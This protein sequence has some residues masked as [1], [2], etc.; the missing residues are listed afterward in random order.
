MKNSRFSVAL[1]R[2][3]VGAVTFA[4][5][6]AGSWVGSS[7]L[8]G[9]TIGEASESADPFGWNAG[10]LGAVLSDQSRPIVDSDLPDPF[11][12]NDGSNAYIYGT[13]I[14]SDSGWLNVPVTYRT[15]DGG[16]VVVDAMPDVPSWSLEGFVWAPSVLSVADGYVMYVT[17][18][19]PT[20]GR[21]CI[22]M[23]TSTSPIGP[24]VDRSDTPF[25]CQSDL[26]GTIDASPLIDDDGDNWLLYKNDGNCCAI[27]TTIWSQRLS[28]DGTRLVGESNALLSATGGWEGWLIEG[29]S[30]VANGDAFTLFY[31]ANRWDTEEYAIGYATCAGPAGPCER[32]I[33]GPWV[34][35]G[36]GVAGPGGQEFIELPRVD[37][38]LMVMH[39]WDDDAVGY[40]VGGQR[41]TYLRL[42]RMTDEGPVLVQ[43]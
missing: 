25:V 4:M 27:D 18:H 14:A 1:F 34:E 38:Y 11:L 17:T 26:G 37:V 23:S 13:N 8:A 3:G 32:Q 41:S 12:L 10:S 36:S 29:P 16:S 19:D 28:D 7:R 42:V 2:V 30:M 9:A 22:S 21:Q 24:F 39:G 40:E 31:S 5:L 20:N 35:S 6:M 15:S 43:R 33:D